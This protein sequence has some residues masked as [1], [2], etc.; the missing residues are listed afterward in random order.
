MVR[1]RD[2]RHGILAKVINMIA[3]KPE[4]PA[5]AGTDAVIAETNRAMARLLREAE[6]EDREKNQ[7]RLR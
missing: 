1:L 7:K 5:K 2:K 3:G 4:L 6:K